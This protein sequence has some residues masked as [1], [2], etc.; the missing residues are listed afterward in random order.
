MLTEFIVDWYDESA[1]WVDKQVA[2]ATAE[3]DENKGLV[4]DWFNQ[5]LEQAKEALAPLTSAIF[6]DGDAVLNNAVEALKA[7]A[8][9]SGITV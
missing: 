4:S 6:D 3:S 7:R 5:W 9:K 2:V 8:A 1:R